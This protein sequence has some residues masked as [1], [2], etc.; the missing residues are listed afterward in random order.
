[1]PVVG[2]KIVNATNALYQHIDLA[3]VMTRL[4]SLARNNLVGLFPGSN[5]YGFQADP[6]T[7]CLFAVPKDGST[8]ATSQ[9]V[10][11]GANIDPDCKSKRRPPLYPPQA[12]M[13]GKLFG[14]PPS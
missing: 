12:A 7:F 3:P 6:N 2:P 9:L 13:L 14:R 4:M 8:Q 1:M 11:S 10:G 5:P